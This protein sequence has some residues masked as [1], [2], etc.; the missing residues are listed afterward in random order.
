MPV[1]EKPIIFA[2]H[3]LQRM[4]ERGTDKEAVREALSVL[5]SERPLGEDVFFI[6]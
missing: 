6:D 1:K 4:K 2:I 5:E 3:A